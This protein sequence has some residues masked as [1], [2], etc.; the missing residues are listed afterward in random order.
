MLFLDTDRQ[1]PWLLWFSPNIPLPKWEDFNCRHFIRSQWVKRVKKRWHNDL[2][3]CQNWANIRWMDADQTC[4]QQRSD[5]YSMACFM[6]FTRQWLGSRNYANRPHGW[7]SKVPL[8]QAMCQMEISIITTAQ[9]NDGLHPGNH[10]ISE[11]SYWKQ[12][13]RFCYHRKSFS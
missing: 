10:D 6:M 13:Q 3:M 12:P 5:F 7:W 8:L 11:A 1:Q 4:W 9:A 2:M